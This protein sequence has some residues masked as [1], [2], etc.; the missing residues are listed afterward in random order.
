ML[1][2]DQQV[3]R[4]LLPTVTPINANYVGSGSGWRV[5][6]FRWCGLLHEGID[7][8]ADIGTQVVAAA[9]VVIA[10]ERHP[11][12]GN[13]VEID[14]GNDFTTRYAHLSKISVRDGQVVKR[15]RI[16]AFGN[17]GR[18]DRPH[19]HFE[20]RFRASPRILRV[21]CSLGEQFAQLP[22]RK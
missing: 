7:F 15:G 16:G 5:D 17:T 1:L 6:P 19:L 11:Q 22:R 12:Y 10:A 14:H 13:L 3:K 18:L 20:V 4:A 21:S 9:G 8:V 2:L